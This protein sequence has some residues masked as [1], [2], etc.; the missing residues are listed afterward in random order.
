MIRRRVIAAMAIIAVAVGSPFFWRVANGSQVE[1][2][3]IATNCL[4]GAIAFAILHFRW[5]MKEKRR[6]SPKQARDTFS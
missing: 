6:M 1:L 3:S 2:Y 4:F 5:R